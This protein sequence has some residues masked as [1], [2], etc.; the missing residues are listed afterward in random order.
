MEVT[1]RKNDIKFTKTPFEQI[2]NV[3]LKK[4]NIKAVND[5]MVNLSGYDI[6]IDIII[7]VPKRNVSVSGTMNIL[8]NEIAEKIYYFSGI[9]PKRIQIILGTKED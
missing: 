8:R 4:Y 5:N 1:I 2:I 7:E 9:K 6:N 3:I